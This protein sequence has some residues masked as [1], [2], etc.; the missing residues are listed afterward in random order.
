MAAD[1]HPIITK[2]VNSTHLEQTVCIMN[3]ASGLVGV[4]K[5]AS[6]LDVYQLKEGLIA[7]NDIKKMV[8]VGS[9]SRGHFTSK[10]DISELDTIIYYIV[11]YIDRKTKQPLEMSPVMSAV[12][13]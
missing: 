7:P 11:V 4:P 10:F 2:I 13:S 6:R 1:N 9:A 12:V 5:D 3:S 8:N